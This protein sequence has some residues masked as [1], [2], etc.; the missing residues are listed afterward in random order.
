MAHSPRMQALIQKIEA[1]D[2]AHFAALREKGKAQSDAGAKAR[3]KTL[4]KRLANL[5]VARATRARAAAKRKAK[6]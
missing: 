2:A 4:E 6:R 5:S 1:A 3:E